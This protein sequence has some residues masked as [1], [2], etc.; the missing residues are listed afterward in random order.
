MNREIRQ[1]REQEFMKNTHL[2][3]A[4]A[5]GAMLFTSGC[6]MAP[7]KGGKATTRQLAGHIEQ[8]VAQGDNPA[9]ASR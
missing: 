1:I 6:G 5:L 8:T 9:Q 2:T 4:L 7:L 3:L